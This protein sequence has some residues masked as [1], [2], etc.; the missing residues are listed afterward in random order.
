MA[1][2]V[3]T[4]IGVRQAKVGYKFVFERL[5]PECK[6]CDL[7]QVCM[8]SLEPGRVYVVIGVRD[9]FHSC[10]IHEKGVRVVEVQEAEVEATVKSQFAVEGGIITFNPIKCENADCPYVSLCMPI[11]LRPGDKCKI[12]RVGERIKGSP[13]GLSLVRVLLQKV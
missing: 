5:L 3:L 11:G 8:E 13:C 12:V 10:P 7:Y 2:K 1:K 4:L 9:I 6:L